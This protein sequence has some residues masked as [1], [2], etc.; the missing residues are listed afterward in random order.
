M[1]TTDSYAGARADFLDY[2]TRERGCS[3]LTVRAYGLDVSQF[4]D[5][6]KDNLNARPLAE[7]THEDIRD[8]LGFMLRHGYEKRSA[9]RKLS[10]VKSF[11]R[12]LV[13]TDR[14]QKNPAAAVKGPRSER[15]LPGSLTQQQVHDV[16]N[17][18]G[19]STAELRELAI[20]ETL[21]GSGLRATELVGLNVSD[22]DF[23]S[24]SIRVRGKG[25]K[26]RVVPLGRVERAALERY[27]AVR[28]D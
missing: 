15:H 10:A 12:Y 20:I 3:A 4:L 7:L 26:E 25:N 9:G 14:L 17:V 19:D 18:T 6:C 27:I 23:A 11:L 28:P 1:T 21:Y 2:L 13:R 5:F 16:L 24:E 22:V 8:Y